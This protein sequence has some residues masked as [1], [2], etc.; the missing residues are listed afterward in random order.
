M[1]GAIVY[2]GRGG[3][4]LGVT[5]FAL[6]FE[7]SVT[8]SSWGTIPELHEVVALARSGA[9]TTETRP[10]ALSDALAAYADLEHGRVVGRA[11]VTLPVA[12]ST[13]GLTRTQL[14]GRPPSAARPLDTQPLCHRL[15]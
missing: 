11:V 9:I 8:V 1:G 10:Y 12:C 5:A 15:N 6:P 4:T 14:I 7:T 3:G 13:S 2:V